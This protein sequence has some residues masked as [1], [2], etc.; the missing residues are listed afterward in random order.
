MLTHFEDV[1]RGQDL[2]LG[3]VLHVG[4]GRCQ[5][6]DV[7]IACEA[8]DITLAECDPNKIYDLRARVAGLPQV[9]IETS[10]IVSEPSGEVALNT[11]NDSR[12]NSLLLPG[13]LTHLFPNLKTSGSINLPSRPLLDLVE[14]LPDTTGVANLL[15]LDLLGNELPL[16]RS[17][18]TTLL[19]R[20]DFIALTVENEP[21]FVDGSTRWEV[22]EFLRANCFRSI[23]QDKPFSGATSFLFQ[24]DSMVRA[25]QADLDALRKDRESS[26][27]QFQ[28]ELES[29]RKDHESSERQFQADLE[30]IRKDRESSERQYQADLESIRKDHESSERQFQADLELLREDCEGTEQQLSESLSV[31]DEARQRCDVIGTQLAK[32]ETELYGAKNDFS[33]LHSEYARLKAELDSVTGERSLANKLLAKCQLDLSELRMRYESKVNREEQLVDL[34][35]QLRDKLELASRYYFKLQQQHP[36]LLD[37]DSNSQ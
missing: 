2:N 24:L 15:V 16:L 25:L 33:V 28:A 35:S 11:C 23:I 10:V 27:R 30:S 3:S 36:E 7:Y 1:L 21:L 20:F 19:G 32:L 18:P 6:L 14:Q 8:K 17:L 4:A 26:E 29:S 37:Q 5:E 13:F 34:V 9:A 22:F 31:V 12:F